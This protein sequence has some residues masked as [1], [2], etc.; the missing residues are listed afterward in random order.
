MSARFEAY[1]VSSPTQKGLEAVRAWKWG[2]QVSSPLRI[3]STLSRESI[4]TCTWTP[5]IIIWRPHQ[6]VRSIRVA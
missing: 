2:S 3:G 5:Q 1:P 4:P 6:R